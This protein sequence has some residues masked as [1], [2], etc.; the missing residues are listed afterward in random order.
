MESMASFLVYVVTSFLLFIFLYARYS[1]FE[2]DLS[3]RQTE[4]VQREEKVRLKIKA[5]DEEIELKRTEINAVS[6]RVEALRT[7]LGI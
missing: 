1:K 3:K 5:M 4:L 7:E 6:E 2:S